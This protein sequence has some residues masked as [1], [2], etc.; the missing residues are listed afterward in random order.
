MVG[1]GDGEYERARILDGW[2][3]ASMEIVEVVCGDDE[4]VDVDAGGTYAME[5]RR[6]KLRAQADG[7]G[8]GDNTGNRRLRRTA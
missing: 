3:D 2:D 4:T 5:R 8:N 1:D 6:K 7:G